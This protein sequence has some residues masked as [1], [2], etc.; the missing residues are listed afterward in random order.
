[1]YMTTP[2]ITDID[3]SKLPVNLKYDRELVNNARYNL[4]TNYDYTIKELDDEINKIRNF[5]GKSTSCLQR[6]EKDQKQ[7]TAIKNERLLDQP[8]KPVKKL[9][10]DAK[11]NELFS[12]L[13]QLPD[14]IF[15][16]Y[17]H[18][19]SRESVAQFIKDKTAFDK[20]AEEYNPTNFESFL[21]TIYPDAVFVKPNIDLSGGYQKK[22]NRRR[23]SRRRISRRR[24]KRGQTKRGQTKRNH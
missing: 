3:P 17:Y 6:F 4:Y 16:K 18:T 15:N 10:E 11:Y 14:N 12:Q 5:C 20:L 7:I 23:I 13:Q 8:V 19:M 24:T 22:Y 1:M 2:R 21:K 9:E